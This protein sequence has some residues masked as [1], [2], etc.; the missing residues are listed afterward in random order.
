MP[1]ERD[2][3]FAPRP[4]P[5]EDLKPL[6]IRRSG[7]GPVESSAC[8]S[9]DHAARARLVIDCSAIARWSAEDRSGKAFAM[10]V[11]MSARR[12]GSTDRSTG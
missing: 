12:L 9:D 4:R 2:D 10:F 7:R 1:G 8:A 11:S 6:H 5:F 3:P